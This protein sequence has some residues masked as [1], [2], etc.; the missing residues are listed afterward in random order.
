M[1][2]A[3]GYSYRQI[4]LDTFLRLSRDSQY[5]RLS[6]VSVV[7]Y[8]TL[9][10]RDTNQS[11][12]VTS[13]FEIEDALGKIY[14]LFYWSGWLI[15]ILVQITLYDIDLVAMPDGVFVTISLARSRRYF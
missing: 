12:F 4:G 1:G 2:T 5:R 9:L 8:R 10:G 13:F 14:R 7:V 3:R 15:L 6:P 11:T